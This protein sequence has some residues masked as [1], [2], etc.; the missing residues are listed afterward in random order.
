MT[1]EKV[2]E[3]KAQLQDMRMIDDD[4]KNIRKDKILKAAESLTENVGAMAARRLYFQMCLKFALDEEH[5]VD[6]D[7]V[8]EMLA[9]HELLNVL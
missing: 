5:G 9:I 2:Q 8:A 6:D 7:D 3:L 1:K 4:K